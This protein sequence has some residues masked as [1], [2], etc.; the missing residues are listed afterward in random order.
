MDVWSKD[1]AGSRQ[2]DSSKAEQ[3][4]PWNP[5]T[6]RDRGLRV[7]GSAKGEPLMSEVGRLMYLTYLMYLMYLDHDL[8]LLQAFLRALRYGNSQV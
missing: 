3:S 1:E 4:G 2:S 7:P 8:S 5:C 6:P